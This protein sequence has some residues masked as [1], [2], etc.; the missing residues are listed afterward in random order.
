MP[1][2]FWTFRDILINIQ[3]GWKLFFGID[4]TNLPWA[5][6]IFFQK[7]L[8]DGDAECQSIPIPVLTW[9]IRFSPLVAGL[10]NASWKRNNC[11]IPHFCS[12]VEIL[13]E[14][15]SG[16]ITT[17]VHSYPQLLLPILSEFF[18]IPLRNCIMWHDNYWSPPRIVITNIFLRMMDERS[19]H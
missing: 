10:R 13:S 2:P 6:L 19:V 15:W 7:I 18:Q 17:S 8:N 4:A 1:W 14:A 3:K 12:A 9:L 5:I 11:V 16:D